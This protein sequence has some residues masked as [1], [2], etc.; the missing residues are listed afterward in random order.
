[1][2][3]IKPVEGM[4]LVFDAAVHVHATAG[5]GITLDRGI[6]VDDLELL[7]VGGDAELV[8][9]D[10][11]HLGEHRALRLPALGAAAYVIVGNIA[12]EAH[13]HGR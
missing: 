12:L 8:A 9:S 2:H 4:V 13:G 6:G 10:D 11:R 5:A 1:M 3:E 7:G